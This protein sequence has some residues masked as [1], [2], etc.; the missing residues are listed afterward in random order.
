[1]IHLHC[2]SHYSLLCGAARPEQLV[3]R[4]AGFGQPALALTDLNA[5]HG[6]VAFQK[7]CDAAGIRA[8]HGVEIT[9]DRP[10]GLPTGDRPWNSRRAAAP[11]PRLVPGSLAPGR[12]RAVLLARDAEGYA[13]I[14][15]L[16][17]A[18]QLRP[19]FD[20]CRDLPP[21][22]REHAA[23]GPGRLFCLTDSE[24]LLGA[25]TARPGDLAAL[26]DIP[27]V[28]LVTA[29]GQA[30][31]AY[32]RLRR[33]AQWAEAR[34]VPVVAGG[35]AWADAPGGLA[36]QRLLSAIRTCRTLDSLDEAACAPAGAWLRPPVEM[37]ILL[38]EFPRAC[39]ETEAIADT[40]RFRFELGAWRYPVFPLPP[41]EDA[42]ALLA[43]LCREGL[44]RRG[45]GRVSDAARERLDRELAV[46]AKLGFA[47]YLLIV[48]DIVR[49][50][51][52]RGVPSVGRGSAAN[53][54]V[55]YA[56]GITHV[57]PLAHD[58][59]FE[60]FLNP[61]RISPPD[62][63]LDFGWKDRD[64]MLAYIYR[65]YGRDRTA[66]ICNINRFSAR[67]ALRETARAHGWSAAEIGAI[68]RRLPRRALEDPDAVA[69]VPEAAALPLQREPY[70]SLLRAARALADFPR[71]LGVHAGGVVIGDA[72]LTRLF[73]LQ[74]A[75]KGLQVSQ[76]DMH[77][78][79]AL[80]LVKIDLLSQRGLS[81]I[82]DTARAVARRHGVAL[83]LGRPLD[84]DPATRRLMR[85]GETLGCFYVE[86]PGMRS[87]LRR[88]KA[89]TFPVVVAASSVIRPGPAD[90]GMGRSFVRRHLGLEP[91]RLPHPALG[92]LNETYGVMVYQEDVM[93]TLAAV[94]GMSLGEADIMRRAMSFKGDP[95]DFLALKERF[96]AGAR[97]TGAAALVGD[98]AIA[99]LWRQI[100]TF[101]G[102]AFC[103][104]HSASY[105]VLSFQA[106]W[107]K[108]HYPAEFM[109]AVLDNGGGYYASATY[110][111]EARR[112]GLRILL[113]HVNESEAGFTGGDG[114]IR[115]G[116]GRVRGLS[117][118]SLAAL[119]AAR[120]ANGPF[121]SLDDLLARAPALT[122]PEVDNLIR[123]GACDGLGPTRPQLLWRHVALR[124]RRRGAALSPVPSLFPPPGATAPAATPAL[125]LPPAPSDG[126]GL[127]EFSPD[128]RLDQEMEVLGFTPSAHPLAALRPRLQR[129][130]VVPAADLER[131]AGRRVK[132]AG[133]I[134]A[135]KG[136][137]VRSTGERMKFLTLEDETALCEIT[138]FPR[139][140]ARWGRLL[141]TRGPYV[142]TG[143]VENDHGSLSVTAERVKLL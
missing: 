83:D 110:L 30:G 19:D 48:W 26:G 9:D 14:C 134:V 51:G 43:R 98:A 1:M 92:F 37:E 95:A 129:A 85:E 63:D 118:R 131:R 97:R 64:A 6:A 91:A 124:A 108:A 141:L 69:T 20:L 36:L 12:R 10:G 72:P 32:R 59:Y 29:G 100:S 105:A 41:G 127:R 96:L 25:L 54:L 15:R 16:V 66:M 136:A 93:R 88:L 8:I 119:L 65:K 31:P 143:R 132:V 133:L 125:R 120:R 86:S 27:R 122:R 135:A 106:A 4:A 17:T 46:V 76:M 128:E 42:D 116:L 3:R 139:E 23:G 55:C 60:R 47:G 62:I 38:S 56:L 137:H 28:L 40:C 82:A 33:L 142:V 61:E 7:A 87:L 79:E 94:A 75:R 71:H 74:W 140:Y 99:E 101:A 73:P 50:A 24:E 52:E 53:S 57:D 21:F 5:L 44:A 138:L 13:A 70:R 90:S 123:C 84:D 112:L 114:A 103:K 109:A 77:A 58:L 115:V 126:A 67:S 113:P 35:D 104:A 80:G 2:H 78:V 89:D 117:R 111:E 102:Y 49:H 45:R 11:P 18:R 22:L 81:V 121:G 34:Q 107:L 39:V 68:A 130:G